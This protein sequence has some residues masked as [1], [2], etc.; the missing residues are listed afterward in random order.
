MKAPTEMSKGTQDWSKRWYE[1][2]W[3]LREQALCIDH[4]RKEI[5]MM[6]A[7]VKANKFARLSLHKVRKS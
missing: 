5:E 3:M 7:S 6:D 4:L 1:T 2:E